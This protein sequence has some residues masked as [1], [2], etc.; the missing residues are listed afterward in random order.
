MFIVVEIDP[1]EVDEFIEVWKER[2][3][4]MRRQ[5]G[6]RSFHLHRALTP[7]ASYQLV[8]VAV[9]DSVEALRAAT[10]NP[11]FQAG[12]REAAARFS[13]VAHPGVYTSVMEATAD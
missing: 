11:D 10:A 8:N 12:L 5:P 7:D 9:W 6:F 1:D 2:A 3:A 13:A 4:I